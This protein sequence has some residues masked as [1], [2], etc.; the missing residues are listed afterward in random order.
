MSGKKYS[1]INAFEMAN[2]VYE[3]NL[4][5]VVEASE[6]DSLWHREKTPVEESLAR[7][8]FTA[9]EKQGRC[10][11]VCDIVKRSEDYRNIFHDV[12]S[13]AGMDIDKLDIF[14]TAYYHLYLVR[15][16]QDVSVSFDQL[17]GISR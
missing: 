2:Y 7:V 15:A 13:K 1:L 17:A 3:L 6:A 5:A 12:V 16:G 10:G 4:N 14:M 8:I 9:L 11:E